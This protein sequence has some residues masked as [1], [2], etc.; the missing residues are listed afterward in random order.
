MCGIAGFLTAGAHGDPG[1]ILRSMTR[2]ITHRGPDDSGFFERR[3]DSN[4]RYLALGFRRLAIIDLNTGEQPKQ[5]EDGRFVIVFNGEIYNFQALRDE[6]KALGSQ[7]RT[8]SDTEVILEAYRHWGEDCV[9]HLRGMFA[10]A[11]WDAENNRLFLARDRFGKKPLFLYSTSDSIVFASEIKSILRWP[12]F[13]RVMDKAALSEYLCY[14]YVPGPA[15]LFEKITKLPPGNTATWESGKFRIRRYFQPLDGQPANGNVPSDPV[16]GFREVLEESV[17]LR[18]ISDVPY[19]AFLS[20]GIDSSVVVAMMAAISGQPVNTF[21][22]GFSESNYSELGYARTIAEQFNCRHHELEVSQDH[23]IEHLPALTR[24]RDAPVAEPSDIPIYLLSVEASRHVKMVLTGEGSD[25]ALAG[26]PKHRFETYTNAYQFIPGMIRSR[27]IEPLVKALPYRFRRAKTA[28]TN[29]GL[30]DLE[31]RWPRWFGAMTPSERDR[32]L[33]HTSS[34]PGERDEIQFDVSAGN[35]ALR[36]ILYF[37][38]TSWLPD[39]LLERGDRMTMGAS[40]EARMPFMDHRLIEYVS[41]LPDSFRIRGRQDKWVLRQVASQLIPK[42]II[43]RPKVGFRVPVNE[44]FQSSMRDY[45]VDSLTGA[46]SATRDYYDGDELN[47]ILAEHTSGRQNHE[48]LL[49]TLLT[50]EVWHR[51]YLASA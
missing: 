29:L 7:F 14:R 39:N 47:R 19:G 16:G 46:A 45:L 42:S 44:W 33:A 8:Q 4:Q 17:R 15:T 21:S 28:I 50:L 49:W 6:L 23:L 26:Y 35:S 1:E 31:V 27:L 32:L 51:E 13:E 12:G 41:G 38:Q 5:T 20:G 34:S 11:L 36:N 37:D 22:V 18:M 3:V 48:K 2:E 30:E 9:K 10:F 40:I 25:E 24:Y 43:D